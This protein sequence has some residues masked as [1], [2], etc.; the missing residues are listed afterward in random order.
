M[1]H[2]LRIAVSVFLGLMIVA[3]AVLWV[4]SYWKADF[5]NIERAPIR[6]VAGSAFGSIAFSIQTPPN[7]PFPFVLSFESLAATEDGRKQF[8]SF[9]RFGFARL[10]TSYERMI[11]MPTWLPIAS[12]VA[13]G[14]ATW[15]PFSRRFSLRT[16][17]IATTV[18]AIVLG[19]VV[20]TTP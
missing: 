7:A 1:G 11:A 18:I 13:F 17:L 8:E 2:R 19:L 9:G 20:W 16:L 3:L 12:L 5:I 10:N 14:I 15:L 4:R 6:Y